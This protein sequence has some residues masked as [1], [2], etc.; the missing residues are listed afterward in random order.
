MLHYETLS[1][2]KHSK[3]KSL[4]REQGASFLLPT[5]KLI[6]ETGQ[7]SYP[8][9]QLLTVASELELVPF[10]LPEGG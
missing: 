9:P 8:L 2:I 6:L 4:G 7:S 10:L 5:G 3:T 1:R